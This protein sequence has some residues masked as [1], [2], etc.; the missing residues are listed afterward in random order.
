MELEPLGYVST[1]AEKVPRFY[2]HSDIK[3]SLVLDE[4]YSAGVADFRPGQKISVI[5]YFHKS[6]PFTPDNM[7]IVPSHSVEL[8][9]VFST[10]SPVRP[11]PIGLSVVKISEVRGSVIEVTGLDMLDGTPILDIKPYKD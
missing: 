10:R 1:D 4:Q 8:R 11:N 6:P 2:S 7:R 5:F 3:G 9:G